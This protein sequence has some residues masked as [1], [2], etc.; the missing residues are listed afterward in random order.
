MQKF[1]SHC[2]LDLSRDLCDLQYNYNYI[3]VYAVQTIEHFV[4]VL[5]C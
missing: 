3:Y 1:L 4:F 5:F 2:A